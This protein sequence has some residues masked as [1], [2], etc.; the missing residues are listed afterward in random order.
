MNHDLILNNIA[1]HIS[2]EPA[3]IA[4]FTSL[5][6]GKTL[7]RKQS[8]LRK[9]DVCRY[10]NFVTRGCLRI[11]QLDSNGLE[12]IALFAAEDWWVA[13]LYSFLTQSPATHF[14]DA[15]EDTQ[16]WQI[17]KSDIERLYRE[18]PKFERFFR[19]MH[20][21]AFIAQQE[22]IMQNISATAEERYRQFRERY[23]QLE[24]RVPQKQIAAYLGIT[25]EFLSMLRRKLLRD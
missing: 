21:N 13:D 16:L 6:R 14:I 17:E 11:Y 7:A 22:R 25:P 18:V 15:L 4:F 2:L 10:T 1:R 23:P 8:L 3:E 9:G 12:H 5:L 20:Q 19:I 24:R